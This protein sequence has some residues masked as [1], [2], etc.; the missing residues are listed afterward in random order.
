MS[1]SKIFCVILGEKIENS[2]PIDIKVNETVGDLKNSI[3]ERAHFDFPAHTMNLW[4]VNITMNKENQQRVIYAK[5]IKEY[6]GEVLLPNKCINE[7][8]SKSGDI[9]IIVQP[10]TTTAGKCHPMFYLSN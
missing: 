2:L 6:K 3:K 10:P 1:S 5:D 4:R 8:F 7:L 9:S